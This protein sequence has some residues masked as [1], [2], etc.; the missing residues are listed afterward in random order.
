MKTLTAAFLFVLVIRPAHAQE[1]KS[2]APAGTRIGTATR[3]VVLCHDLEQ[4]LMAA[5]QNHDQAALD[6]LLASDFE[7]RT[8]DPPGEPIPRA[9]WLQQV[10]KFG[11]AEAFSFRQM[12][13]RGLENHAI[14]SF[15]LVERGHG[16]Q[17]AH[18]VVDVWARSGSEWKLTERYLS[19]ARAAQYAAEPRPTGKE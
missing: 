14:A 13:V 17:T 15:V 8:P 11:E 16:R 1:A 7:A 5:Q 3:L 10:D 9:T 19:P 2:A 18:F 6:R 4:Q 12:A